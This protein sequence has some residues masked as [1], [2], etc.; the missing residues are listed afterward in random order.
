MRAGQ[1]L[2]LA[3]GQV[4]TN[5]AHQPG[6]PWQYRS[7]YLAPAFLQALAPTGYGLPVFPQR[8][9]NDPLLFARLRQVHRQLEVAG[10]STQVIGEL[11]H[12]LTQLIGRHSRS[13]LSAPAPEPMLG[14]VSQLLLRTDQPEVG[15][16]T[17]TELAAE[18]GMSRFQ[19][20]RAFALAT[21]LS[22]LAYL[23]QRR[24]SRAKQLL[25]QGATPVF[26]A[27][28]TGFFDQSHFSRHFKRVMGATPGQYR[29]LACTNV[30]DR[31]G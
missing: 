9:L 16:L 25:Q 2:V 21:G 13:N 24:L 12:A 30:Q 29:A 15:R 3:P 7:F 27:L 6:Q 10:P 31:V 19:F 18:G 22:P 23:T 28:E 17:V 26:A 5:Y 20:T 1:L 11:E 14:Y 4:H 8:L